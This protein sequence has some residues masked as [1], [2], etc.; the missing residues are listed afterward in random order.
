[1]TDLFVSYK[2]E[3][4]P[5]VAPLV[6]ALEAEGYSVWWDAQ[7][8]GGEAWRDTICREL[9]AARLV[10]VIWSK[11]SVGPQGRFV[12][13]E[14]TRAQRR[15]AYL[16]AIIDKV[17]PPLGFGEIQSLNLVRWKGDPGDR[18]YQALLGAIRSRLGGAISAVPHTTGKGVSRRT[19]IVGGAVVA[20]TAAGVA[21]WTLLRPG[22][23]S[24]KSIAVLPFANLSGDPAQ[25]YFSD[26]I[27]EELR[28]ALSRVAGLT[29]VARTSSE[30]VRN[31]DAKTAAN[32][33]G[34]VTILTGSV[35]QSPATIRVSAQ[36]IDGKTGIE[37]WSQSYDRAPGDVIK[38]Q[39]DIAE[40]VATSLAAALAGTARA[41]VALGSTLNAEAQNLLL[42]AIAIAG[43]G[44]R[45]DLT[46][47][48]ALL[49]QAL[50]IDPNY[51][52]AYVE[53]SRVLTNFAG[54]FAT[55]EDLP[56]YRA[57]AERN[58]KRA[59]Q[60]APELASAHNALAEL[61][62]VSLDFK[63][64][65]QEFKRALSLSPR[66]A[67]TLRDNARFGSQLGRS[68]EALRL[69]D[70]AIG[71][72]PLSPASYTSRAW[73]LVASRLFAEAYELNMK[74]ARRW[75]AFVSWL[76]VCFCLV[77]LDRLDEALKIAPN[78]DKSGSS[79]GQGLALALIY[80]RKGRKQDVESQLAIV[81][82][83]FGDAASYQYAQVY[84]MLGDAVRALSSL[85]RAWEIRDSG[86]LWLRVDPTLD[87][88]RNEPRFKS[89][90]ERLDFPA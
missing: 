45:D 81:R 25:A 71:I 63:A 40:N 83:A 72:D 59:I 31:D 38:I 23:A 39:T 7:I 2:A 75:P 3:D 54:Y 76:Q 80:A 11:R 32:K 20:A 5:R 82:G 14:A 57:E 15:G 86:L 9:D 43:P 85:D 35:R 90:L 16:P 47:A 27:A 21:G 52:D 8:G 79:G 19:A 87:P 68:A 22:K 49:D 50:A 48:Q 70:E 34:V 41:A 65:D 78:V 24:A 1:M 55:A 4:R 58:A 33:L 28:N 66:D 29:V 74:I 6:H 60:I 53:K 84:S 26:G 69:V 17:D 13:D 64:A 62:R 10:L 51:A 18:K 73:V 61:Y 89:L 36:L 88:L 30:A 46:E 56:H 12:H 67:T 42:K 44:T 77:Q 37:K